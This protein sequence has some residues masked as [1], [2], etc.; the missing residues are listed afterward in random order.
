MSSAISHI[1][2]RRVCFY[3]LGR[4]DRRDTHQ[5]P[6]PEHGRLGPA[7]P[8]RSVVHAYDFSG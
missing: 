1:N 7:L 5:V 4:N 2:P 6:L 3:Y 8:T